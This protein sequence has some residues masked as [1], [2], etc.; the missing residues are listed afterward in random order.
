M[1]VNQSP[2]YEQSQR[3]VNFFNS[4]GRA[5]L[6]SVIVLYQLVKV[7]FVERSRS[8]PNL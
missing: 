3:T 4:L 7:L 2:N 1:R 5:A 8:E 6:G